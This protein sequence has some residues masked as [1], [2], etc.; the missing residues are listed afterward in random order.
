MINAVN[1][2]HSTFAKSTQQERERELR[3]YTITD[4]IM[5][6]QW[7]L[8]NLAKPASKRLYRFSVWDFET[9]HDI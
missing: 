2:F 8:R 7:F 6:M 3:Y 9:L 4:S 5:F 1:T